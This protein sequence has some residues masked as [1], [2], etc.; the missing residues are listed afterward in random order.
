MLGVTL[1]SERANNGK[2]ERKARGP[3][4]SISLDTL[5]A[6]EDDM[7]L[8]CLDPFRRSPIPKF[9]R[10]RTRRRGTSLLFRFLFLALLGL[11]RVG[12]GRCATRENAAGPKY[13]KTSQ[14]MSPFNRW[15]A[16]MMSLAS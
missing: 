14:S 7:T 12:L 10:A 2:L 1:S 13:D 6:F 8:H 15:V 3:H 9:S 5:G 4:E 16:P 11:L